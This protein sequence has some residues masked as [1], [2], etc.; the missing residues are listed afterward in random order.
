[1][2]FLALP[3]PGPPFSLVAALVFSPRADPRNRSARVRPKT[4]EPPTHMKSRRVVPSQVS[5]PAN[6]GMTS[7]GAL[8]TRGGC[9]GGIIR[10]VLDLRKDTL[11]GQFVQR[12]NA[13]GGRSGGVQGRSSPGEMRGAAVWREETT[14]RATDAPPSPRPGPGSL[15]F[16]LLRLVLRLQLLAFDLQQLE[17][18]HHFRELGG[19]G[20]FAGGAGLLKGLFDDRL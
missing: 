11:S 16:R 10:R 13:H 8:G 7:M 20:R 19:V 15:F 9:S 3:K 5:L 6:P 18:L 17:R 4:A 2:T 12:K 14:R 1:M